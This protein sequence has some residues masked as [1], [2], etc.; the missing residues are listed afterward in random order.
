MPPSEEYAPVVH[1]PLKLKGSGPS[2][3][4]KIKKKKKKKKAHEEN[5]SQNQNE[6][7]SKSIVQSIPLSEPSNPNKNEGEKNISNKTHDL[8]LSKVDEHLDDTIDQDWAAGKTASERAFEEMRKKRL[9]DRI[10]KEGLK[11]HKQRVEELNKYLSNLS[12]HHDMPRI[13]PG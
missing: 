12:E 8:S 5:G 6:N 3:I 11:T 10:A 2:G 4:R 7:S 9:M 1:G 13:G